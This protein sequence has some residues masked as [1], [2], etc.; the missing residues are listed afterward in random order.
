MRK[1]LNKTKQNSKLLIRKCHVCGQMIESVVEQEKCSCCG[2][3]FL[4]L[5][6][7][8]KIHDHNDSEQKS[9]N[10]QD[11]FAESHELDQDD[12]VKGLYILW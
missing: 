11:L 10:Y 9:T 4:P 6:Y 2:K 3:Y 12:L 1:E 7:F 8:Q 5:N